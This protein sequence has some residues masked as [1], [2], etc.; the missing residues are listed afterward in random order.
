MKVWVNLLPPLRFLDRTE[1]VEVEVP[2]KIP[3]RELVNLIADKTSVG[4][5]G[6]DQ[7]MVLIGDKIAGP[8]DPLSENIEVRLMLRPMGG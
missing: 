2:A 8:N 3:V 4:K 5:Y 6:Q 7:V 1:R